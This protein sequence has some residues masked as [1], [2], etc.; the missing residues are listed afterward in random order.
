MFVLSSRKNDM[1]YIQF[2]VYLDPNIDQVQQY[3]K[4][5]NYI[6]NFSKLTA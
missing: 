2:F 4:L 1:P 3:E 5:R 6:Q